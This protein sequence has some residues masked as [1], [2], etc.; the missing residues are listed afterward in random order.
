[1]DQEWLSAQE[2]LVIV[3]SP[4]KTFS[5]SGV[6]KQESTKAKKQIQYLNLHIQTT[7]LPFVSLLNP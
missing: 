3:A 5:N 7:D 6:W 4:I 1:M 2:K